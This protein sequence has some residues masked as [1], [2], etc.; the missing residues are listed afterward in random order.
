[1]NK[2][3]NKRVPPDRERDT[4]PSNNFALTALVLAGVI[5]LVGLAYVTGM[6]K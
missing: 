5:I 6:V 4:Y 1:M 2:R 3:P